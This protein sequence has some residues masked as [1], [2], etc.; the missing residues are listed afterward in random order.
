MNKPTFV[1]AVNQ[2]LIRLGFEYVIQAEIRNHPIEIVTT[3][4][5][6]RRALA[7]NDLPV[8]IVDFDTFDFSG[9][10]EMATLAQAFS[11]SKWLFVSDKVNETFVLP[12][13][14]ALPGANFILKT[15]THDIIVAALQ[16]TMA[17]KKYFCSEALDVILEGR[18]RKHIDHKSLLTPTENELVQ[19]LAQGKT[20]K[21]I[22]EERCLS[23]HTVNTHRKNIFRKLEVNSV[24]ELIKYA[25]KHGLVDLTE[26][27]I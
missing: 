24:Q 22:A 3:K 20:T 7:M 17:G 12:L 1:L 27:Y 5:E 10:E 13:T 25:L 14:S 15:N 2:D 18:T 23:H 26:Y 19:L 8:V 16:S 11:E 9:I 6:L 21:E 4:S